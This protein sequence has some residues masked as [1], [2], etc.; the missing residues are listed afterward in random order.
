[1]AK[2]REQQYFFTELIREE[3]ERKWKTL[4]DK[5]IMYPTPGRPSQEKL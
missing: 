4:Q 1:M 2:F 5:G 3:Y